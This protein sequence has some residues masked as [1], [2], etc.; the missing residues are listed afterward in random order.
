MQAHLALIYPR[1]RKRFIVP[2]GEIRVSFSLALVSFL[3]FVGAFA[4]SAAPKLPPPPLATRFA[5]EPTAS[6]IWNIEA[7]D[8]PKYF[9][10][11]S[12]RLDNDGHPH[13]AYGG[14]H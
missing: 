12:L 4:T 11:A 6:F 1:A 5:E 9:S 8:A 10:G 2:R 13:I 3:L 7:V 14:D